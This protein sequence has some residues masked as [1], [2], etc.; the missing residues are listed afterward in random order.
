MGAGA[1][2]LEAL[3]LLLAIQPMVK[4]GGHHTGAAVA[5]IVTLVVP[6]CCWPGCCGPV[7]L[8]RR[9]RPA[10]P[11]VRVRPAALALF[12]LGL[13]FGA[14]W[15]YALT[16]RRSSSADAGP[17]GSARCRG[18]PGRGRPPT[19]APAARAG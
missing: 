7:G 9:H 1:L 6:A 4:L 8:V 19:T 3:V 10:G 11:A 14:V 18:R 16:V 13:I 12:V 2:A 5:A 15:A 17:S